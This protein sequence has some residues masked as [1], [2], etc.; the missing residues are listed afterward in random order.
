MSHTETLLKFPCRFP[1]KIMGQANPEFTSEVLNLLRRHA[2]DLT[3][4]DVSQ[5]Q[6]AKQNYVS[7][8]VTVNA[9]NRAQLDAIYMDLSASELVL[10]VF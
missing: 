9:V 4:A 3:D 7:L 8:T 2:P 1:L 5:R 10:A 6:S